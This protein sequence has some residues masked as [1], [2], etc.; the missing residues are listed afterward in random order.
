MSRVIATQCGRHDF[1]CGVH[2]DDVDDC[3]GATIK[4]GYLGMP[5]GNKIWT[6][7]QIHLL[8]HT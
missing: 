8:V 3:D 1:W 4:N 2:L 5:L 7:N 6:T